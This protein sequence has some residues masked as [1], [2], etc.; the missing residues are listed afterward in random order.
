MHFDDFFNYN[1][2][3]VGIEVVAFACLGQHT[4]LASVVVE[5]AGSCT[6]VV[7]ALVADKLAEVDST[8]VVEVG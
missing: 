1:L 4:E 2:M 7:A 5:P 3:A 6:V 8:L